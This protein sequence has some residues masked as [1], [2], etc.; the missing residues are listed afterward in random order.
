M[1][2]PLDGCPD[3]FCELLDAVFTKRTFCKSNDRT[4]FTTVFTDT[5]AITKLLQ[6]VERLVGFANQKN[7]PLMKQEELLL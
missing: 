2:V 7:L 5:V 6:V 1:A 3:M 4:L